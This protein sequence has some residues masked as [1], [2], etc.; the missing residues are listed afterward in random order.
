MKSLSFPALIPHRLFG[1]MF[2]LLTVFAPARLR[3]E[4]STFV[5]LNFGEDISIDVPRKWLFLN[6]SLREQL[7]ISAEAMI[8][9]GGLDYKLGGNRIL[10]A[11]NAPLNANENGATMRLS[12]ES[13][14]TLSQDEVTTATAAELELF[15]KEMKTALEKATKDTDD[16]QKA[17]IVATRTEKLGKHHAIVVEYFRTSAVTGKKQFVQVNLIPFRTRAVKLT[18]SYRETHAPIYRPVMQ[19]IRNSLV[20]R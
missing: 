11:A 8:K 9:L 16:P 14:E 3:A 17:E 20:I 6:E 7:K 12:L 15:G 1:L 19:V 18:T 10:V 4:E 5:K 2:A 13:L